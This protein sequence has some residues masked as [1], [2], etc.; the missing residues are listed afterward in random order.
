[1]KRKCSAKEAGLTE[2]LGDVV[3]TP[4]RRKGGVKNDK[5]KAVQEWFRRHVTYEGESYTIDAEQA[6]AVADESFNTI[7]VAR[8]GSGKTRTIVAKIIYL[9]AKCMVKPS[10][11][12]IFV[13]NAN[14]AAEINERLSKMQVDG[15]TVMDG[16]RPAST[17]HAF[18]R[19][20]IYNI[21]GGKD[22]CGK[23]LAGEKE[24]FVRAILRG[25]WRQEDWREIIYKFEKDIDKLAGMMTQFIN[26]AQQK[27]LGGG[28][29]LRENV[30]RKL[31]EEIDERE[32]MFLML[33]EEC[34]KRYH[35]Y[36]LNAG[37]RS[38]LMRGKYAE[39]G[40][41]FNLLVAWAGKVIAEV[42]L[43]I[44]ELLQSKQYILIDEYQDFS[45]L[46]LSVV[47]A[48]REVASDARLFVVGDDWQAIN[49]FA[50]SD[51]EYFKEFHKYFAEGVRRYEIT[52]NY[53][54]DAEIVERA[55]EFMKRAMGEEGNFK[56]KSR[57]AGKVVLVEP[58]ET[59][60]TYSTVGYDKR[61]KRGDKMLADAVQRMLGRV[62]K[63]KTVRYVK[64]I[65]ELMR[66]NR[67]ASE[68]LVL[69]RNNEMNMESVELVALRKCVGECVVG[70]GVMTL[71]EYE[72]RVKYMTMH[73]SKGLEA[74]VVI[75]LE[76]DVGVIPKTHPDTMLYSVFG[77][78]EQA[79]LDDQKRLFYV[80]MTRAKKRLYIIHNAADGDGF[81][82][83]LGRMVEKWEK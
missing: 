8:A 24:D 27:Y 82:K 71:A 44:K 11:I 70:L 10:E 18:S 47:M 36:L 14:A 49:R 53:R 77:E 12:L 29:T 5:V 60:L 54:C 26:R 20:I 72:E 69:H 32:R 57:R 65:V 63:E 39:Y 13:F 76:A 83:Y 21:Y 81:V 38:K 9:V 56:A 73:K 25:M 6:A 2:T 61:V 75:I 4:R 17:F 46:F 74:E 42:G 40:T 51:V 28:E 43:Q 37:P 79:A 64:T 62:P 78:N 41:D 31:A 50:G 16:A 3:G 1:M 55:R 34:Y 22:K 33:G 58:R 48:V 15:D 45:Q 35:W 23:I 67:R 52:T 68:I 30:E 19:H 80:A 7:V 66:A 59:E